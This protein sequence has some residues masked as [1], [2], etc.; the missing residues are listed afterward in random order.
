NVFIKNE[1]SVSELHLAFFPDESKDF[2]IIAES[3]YIGWSPTYSGTQG[4]ILSFYNVSS[5]TSTLEFI[6]CDNSLP[7]TINNPDG[8]LSIYCT[9]IANW[10]SIYGRYLTYRVTVPENISRSPVVWSMEFI[11]NGQPYYLIINQLGAGG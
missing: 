4:N 10:S 7:V 8:W 6:F 3:N 2:E 5:R 9:G 11:C 1:L